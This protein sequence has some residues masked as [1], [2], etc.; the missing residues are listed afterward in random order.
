LIRLS[1]FQCFVQ[2]YCTALTWLLINY[3]LTLV[4]HWCI[5]LLLVPESIWFKTRVFS[6]LRFVLMEWSGWIFVSYLQ[7]LLMEWSDRDNSLILL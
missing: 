3:G 2:P 4:V 5:H 6:R 1:F 7:F